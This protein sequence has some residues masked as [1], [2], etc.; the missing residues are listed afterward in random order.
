MASRRTLT[1]V[2][3]A[4]ILG[5]A[6]ALAV[7]LARN[8]SAGAPGA[9]QSAAA[10][11]AQADMLGD[12]SG[13]AS[14]ASTDPAKEEPLLDKFVSKDPFVPLPTANTTSTSSSETSD[15]T[16]GSTSTSTSTSSL[17]AQVVV[18]GTAYTVSKNDEVP[19]GSPA[20]RIGSVTSSDVTFAVI[21]G[22][23]KNGNSSV[24]V[25]L[26][27]S[28]TATLKSGKEYTLKVSKI[29]NASGGGGSRSVSGGNTI[30]VLS[31]S[32]NNGTGVVTIEVNGQT[33]PDK[34][35]GDTFNTSY[36]QIK[37]LGINVSAQTV[38]M[39]HGDQTLLLRANQVVV[40]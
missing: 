32:S 26:G 27:E 5:A 24:T 1:Y 13:A 7:A 11:Q 4:L 33:Y 25:D 35:V 8:S 40:K 30:S 14:L 15:G 39:M 3:I 31:I 10:A 12:S 2:A 29:G 6:L 21:S 37:I 18:N 16:G 17:S 9:P 38:T 23:L 34:K 20:F 28:V 19:G 22:S 36:G